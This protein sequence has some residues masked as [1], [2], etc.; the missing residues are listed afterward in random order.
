MKLESDKKFNQWLAGLIDGGG[1]FTLVEKKYPSCE[2]TVHLDDESLLRK[3]QNKLGGSIKKRSGVNAIRWRSRKKEVMID[4]VH[5]V[6]GNIRNTVRIPQL[7]RIC[8]ILGVEAIVP[9]KKLTLDNAWITG[10]FDAEGTINYYY[11]NNI[12]QLFVSISNKHKINLDDLVEL[13]GGEI[14][15]D[16]A[17]QGSFKW[18]L[19]NEIVHMGYY[20][21]HLDNPCYSIKSKRL[22]L[23]KQFYEL[24]NRKAY[25]KNNSLLYKSWQDFDEKWKGPALHS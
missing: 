15:F 19:T 23:V 7:Y 10:F 9:Y 25:L 24:Y 14:Y 3:I 6:N 16:K 12:P 21:Y 1:S 17:G 4:L 18:V 13:F 2:I 8:D 22:F 11:K 5:R 20:N